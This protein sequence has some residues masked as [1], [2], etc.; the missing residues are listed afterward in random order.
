[1]SETQVADP[2]PKGAR[3]IIGLKTRIRVGGRED[4]LVPVIIPNVVELPSKGVRIEYREQD[5]AEPIDLG[6]V[7]EFYAGIR[8]D[9][10][11]V[12]QLPEFSFQRQLPA[13][14]NAIGTIRT[15][16]HELRL[17]TGQ[18]NEG[19]GSAFRVRVKFTPEPGS[20]YLPGLKQISLQDCELLVQAGRFAGET[21]PL[22]WWSAADAPPALDPGDDGP[23]ALAPGSDEAADA[24]E[25][26]EAE[27][28]TAR[29]AEP[30]EA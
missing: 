26:G 13:P 17:A 20:L 29:E 18:L 6:T 9:F 24:G 4:A 14:L 7:D 30:A 8:E 12:V 28:A 25:A 19:G 16:I 23:L 5:G 2:A 3:P 11:E 22:S 10:A 21:D 27:P 15:T 1:M